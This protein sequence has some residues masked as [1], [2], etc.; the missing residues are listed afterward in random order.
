[1]KTYLK[2][3]TFYRL[4]RIYMPLT[5]F[6][7]IVLFNFNVLFFV[8]YY[9]T[10]LLSSES[11]ITFSF[12]KKE[13]YFQISYITTFLFFFTHKIDTTC[14]ISQKKGAVINEIIPND[15]L[16]Y[17]YQCLFFSLRDKKGG[18]SR[19]EKRS[20]GPREQKV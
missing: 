13:L 6:L 8:L 11:P 5:L 17:S 4:L 16:L 20:G 1:M 15:I 18:G 2:V 14:T 12:L 19:W 7:L 9:Y 3:S 10:L